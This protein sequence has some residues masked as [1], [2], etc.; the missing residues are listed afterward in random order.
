MVRD[1]FD[2]TRGGDGTHQPLLAWPAFLPWCKNKI[3]LNAVILIIS[4]VNP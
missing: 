3:C 4:I 2:V 1:C